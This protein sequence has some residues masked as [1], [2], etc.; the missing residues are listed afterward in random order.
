MIDDARGILE[1]LKILLVYFKCMLP[2]LEHLHLGFPHR[3]GEFL[4]SVEIYHESL[5]ELHHS[6]KILVTLY[7]FIFAIPSLIGDKALSSLSV[8][9]CECHFHILLHHLL[10][11]NKCLF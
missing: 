2:A 4:V 8:N 3:M 5:D 6:N 9:N 11:V 7:G 1:A 10:S